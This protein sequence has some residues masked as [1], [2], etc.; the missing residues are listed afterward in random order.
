VAA[1]YGTRWLVLER[2]H[3]VTP[4]A[5]ILEMKPGR[6]GSGRR[7]S[8]MPYTGED[9]RPGRGR[10]PALAIFPICTTAGDTL[11]CGATGATP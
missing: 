5:P 2:A 1:D 7:S 11:R 4:L 8:P 10:A 3:I 6:T 9:G